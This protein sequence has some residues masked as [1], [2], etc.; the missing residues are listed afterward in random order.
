LQ[1]A[2][3]EAATAKHGA[4]P[5]VRVIGNEI[6]QVRYRLLPHVFAIPPGPPP[7]SCDEE[8]RWKRP[9]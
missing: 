9:L 7:R 5:R 2:H 4:R 6:E 8:L 1:P 3:D